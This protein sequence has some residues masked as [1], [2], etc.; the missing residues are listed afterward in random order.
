MTDQV[1]IHAHPKAPMLSLS[2]VVVLVVLGEG[3]PVVEDFVAFVRAEVEG[4]RPNWLDLI[5]VA[6]LP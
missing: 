4:E 6:A 1:L 3:P 2:R 5:E